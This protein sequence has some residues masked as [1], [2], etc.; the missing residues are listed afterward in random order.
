MSTETNQ[1]F[2]VSLHLSAPKM[3]GIARRRDL[4]KQ[5]LDAGYLVHC[6]LLE[7]LGK[8]APSTFAIA[9]DKG[10]FWHIL[11]YCGD[12]QQALKEYADT[13]ADPL[14]HASVDW[15]TLATKAMPREW[16][17]GKTLSFEVRICPVI[18]KSQ[19]GEFNRKGAEVDAFLAKCRKVGPDVGV[20]REQVYREWLEL[21]FVRHGGA[22]L[23]SANIASFQ[24]LSLTRRTQGEFR[25]S[26]LIERPD[27]LMRGELEI[28]DSMAFNRLLQRGLGRHR[29]FGYGMLL[30]K[31]R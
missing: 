9:S 21:Q 26:Q 11:G 10:E 7:L 8:R 3:M 31:P 12:D 5:N 23:R 14:I 1:L 16:P 28:T 17:L 18:R 4:L 20:D 25:K 27:A 22:T 2:M 24:V 6:Q 13:Y 19:S 15:T 29:A 30:L